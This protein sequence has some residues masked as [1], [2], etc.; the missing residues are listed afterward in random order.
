MA[1]TDSFSG[2]GCDDMEFAASN[3]RSRAGL[4]LRGARADLRQF[5][6]AGEEAWDEEDD[7]GG[8]EDSAA[9][10]GAAIHSDEEDAG[11]S[12]D[13]EDL[14]PIGEGIDYSET[15]EVD[16]EDA[17]FQLH[18][19]IHPLGLAAKGSE[20]VEWR[21]RD[22]Y[23]HA[24]NNPANKGMR[25]EAVLGGISILQLRNSAPFSVAYRMSLPESA[26][27]K[28]KGLKKAESRFGIENDRI[29]GGRYLGEHVAV[30]VHGVMAPGES[31]EVE[32]PCLTSP[33][34]IDESFLSK[35]RKGHWSMSDMTDTSNGVHRYK[36]KPGVVCLEPDHPVAKLAEAYYPDRVNM[37]EEHTEVEEKDFAKYAN[38][39][40]T[41][42]KAFMTLGDAR[43]NL[44][45]HFTRFVP[46]SSSKSSR[47]KSLKT[48]WTD[49]TE[50][51][52]SISTANPEAFEKAKNRAL[53][54]TYTI[55]GT[56]LVQ[57]A[58]RKAPQ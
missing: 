3:M 25:D 6:T 37:A 24:F 18:A 47:A 48:A 43:K 54:K 26:A 22:M 49:E 30:P 21:L 34:Q 39:L 46:P 13:E 45:I 35:E 5:E 50:I 31:M 19:K 58:P 14:N 38:M 53:D 7:F 12:E 20:S 11:F 55:T 10:A 23:P 2:P 42:H 33:A 36:S 29:R 8:F 28:K 32:V 51:C 1:D 15:G 44:S 17:E 9:P 16:W 40:I 41:Q 56:V 4:G 57:F 27:P 52:D